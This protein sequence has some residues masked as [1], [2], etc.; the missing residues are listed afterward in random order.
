M[1]FGNP[2]GD[3]LEEFEKST[4]TPTPQGLQCEIPCSGCGNVLPIL[5]PWLPT[6]DPRTGQPGSCV[7]GAF[8]QKPAPLGALMQHARAQLPPGGGFSFCAIDDEQKFV[9]VVI[10]KCPTCGQ[11][12]VGEEHP[13]KVKSYLQR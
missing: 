13:H 10:V 7:Q 6:P 5:E 11:L 9:F 4:L 1:G 12:A 8:T 2:L 3:V